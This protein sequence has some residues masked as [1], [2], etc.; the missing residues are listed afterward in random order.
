MA[1]STH[2]TSIGWA[3]T[4]GGT[5]SLLKGGATMSAPCDSSLLVCCSRW[6]WGFWSRG[7]S[8]PEEPAPNKRLKL[9][10]AHKYGRVALLR[11]RASPLLHH[12]APTRIAP[13]A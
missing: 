5:S 1:R 7:E 9:P 6:P 11:R 3:R 13:A 8:G 2:G 4:L 12:L 10:G